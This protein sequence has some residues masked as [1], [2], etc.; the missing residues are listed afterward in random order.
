MN[1]RQWIAYSGRLTFGA[2]GLSNVL[3]NLKPSLLHPV[4]FIGHGSPMN[5]I[6]DNVFSR[7]M[8]A[9]GRQLAKPQL[10][11]VI[12][13]HW[14]TS[15]VQITAMPNPRTIYDFGGF[16]DALYHVQYLAPGAPEFANQSCKAWQWYNVHPNYTW[17]LDHG[18]WSVLINM[19][20]EAD[21]PVVQLSLNTNWNASTHFEFS[22]ELKA[23]RSKGVLILGSGNIVHNFSYMNF[24][25][26]HPGDFNFPYA[27]D[28]AVEANETLKYWIKNSQVSDLCNYNIGN[29]ALKRAIP[30]PEHYLPLLYTMGVLEPHESVQFFNDQI[31]AGAFSMTSFISKEF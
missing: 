31:I 19:F 3:K 9:M 28:W 18:A 10:I 15:G 23:L 4:V 22:R 26:L 21:I 17:G 1:R 30:T 20:P 27:H 7:G 12:S 11:L 13:A 8:K 5:A 29:T 25:A 16:P 24:D 14:E 2:M 6:E